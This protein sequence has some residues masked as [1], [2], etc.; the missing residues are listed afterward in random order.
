MKKTTLDFVDKITVPGDPFA[1]PAN[2]YWALVYLRHGLDYLDRFVCEQEEDV[3]SKVNPE[4][5]LRVFMLGNPPDLASVPK[6][7]LTCAF[8]WYAISACQYVRT[9][10]AIAWKQDGG[11]PKPNDYVQQVIPEVLAFRNKVAAHFAGCTQNSKDSEAD[12]LLSILP[13]LG[14]VNG[15]FRVGTMMVSTRTRGKESCS[16]KMDWSIS[17]VHKRL[18]KRYWPQ[19]K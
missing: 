15:C 8:H 5:K 19:Q 10:G 2:E 12:R 14:F 6:A 13:Q 4:G 17:E 11:W 16:E 1:E 9:V 18:Q 3:R 7:L